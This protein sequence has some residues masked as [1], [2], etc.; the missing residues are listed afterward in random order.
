M[1]YY[2]KHNH[3]RLKRAGV[4]AARPPQPCRRCSW[5]D[6]VVAVVVVVVPGAG[7]CCYTSSLLDMPCQPEL[8]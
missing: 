8:V 2:L 6:V 7:C 5:Q 4:M 1:R 3:G